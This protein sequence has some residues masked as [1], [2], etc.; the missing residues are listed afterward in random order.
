MPRIPRQCQGTSGEP[1]T[2][3]PL[4]ERRHSF[5]PCKVRE[6]C[7]F[8]MRATPLHSSSTH[9]TNYQHCP[10]RRDRVLG[11]ATVAVMT[12]THIPTQS[13]L[14]HWSRR[15]NS[16][17]GDDSHASPSGA[18]D[19]ALL[20]HLPSPPAFLLTQACRRQIKCSRLHRKGGNRPT[21]SRPAACSL[22][23]GRM[24]SLPAWLAGQQTN[25]LTRTAH[26]KA[27]GEAPRRI[28]DSL[29]SVHGYCS[30]LA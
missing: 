18:L 20:F 24:A 28:R 2:S 25:Q 29:H 22:D 8:S 19:Q 12:A 6:D 17:P 15:S 27:A 30:R 7:S 3:P 21:P 5:R 4:W 14:L 1:R 13:I 23:I 10:V 26:S 9:D 11:I 16:S